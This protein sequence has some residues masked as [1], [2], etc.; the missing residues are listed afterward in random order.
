TSTLAVIESYANKEPEI[1]PRVP[2]LLSSRLLHTFQESRERRTACWTAGQAWWADL[3]HQEIAFERAFVAAGGTLL[4]GA[5]PTGWGGV[6]AGYGDQRGLE[7]L[8]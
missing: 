6:V 3:L 4:V 2:V 1:D 7:L 8:V 5:D